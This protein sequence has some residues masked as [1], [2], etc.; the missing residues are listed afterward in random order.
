LL[1]GLRTYE[2][3]REGGAWVIDFRDQWRVASRPAGRT[4]RND[5]LA[6]HRC[7]RVPQGVTSSSFPIPCA[8]RD[9]DT[10]PF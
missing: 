5:V 1:D 4:P 3:H 7:G 6:Q 2:M 9:S 10:P 8:V